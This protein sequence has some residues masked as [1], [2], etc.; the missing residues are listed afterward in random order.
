MKAVHKVMKP[1]K[2]KVL[3]QETE[4]KRTMGKGRDLESNPNQ[5]QKGNDKLFLTIS[6]LVKWEI[7]NMG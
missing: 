1:V 2:S 5:M 4:L 6:L 3:C 7:I